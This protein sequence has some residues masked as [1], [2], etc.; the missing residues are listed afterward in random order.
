YESESKNFFCVSNKL[1]CQEIQLYCAALKKDEPIVVEDAWTHPATAELTEDYLRPH[2]IRSLLDIPLKLNG[3]ITGVLCLEV[4]KRTRGWEPQ[5]IALCLGVADHVSLAMGNAWE[6]DLRQQEQTRY[7][8]RLEHEVR[9]RTTALAVANE[10]LQE[11]EA[12]LQ[13]IFN[14]APFGAA[15]V[16]LYGHFVQVNEEFLRFVGYA[17]K[18]LAQVN[19]L[20]L[21][22]AEHRALY[23]ENFGALLAG[24]ISKFKADSL[25]LHHNDGS[26]WG[27]TTIRVLRDDSGAPLY[28][29]VLVENISEQKGY[30]DQLG[31][32]H[33]AIEQSPLSIL[34]TDPSGIIE[35]A[36]P[37]FCSVTGYELAEVVGQN[38]KVLKSNVHEPA[39]YQDLWQTIKAGK[40]WQGEICNLKKDGTPFWEYA[41]ISPVTDHDG[42]IVSYIAV[43]ENISARKKMADELRERSE[44]ITSIA[45]AALSA[46]I[47]I[48]NSGLISFWNKAAE[49]IFGWTRQEA[50][51]QDLHQLLVRD[52]CRQRFLVNF[53]QFQQS[54]AGSAIG[55]HVEMNALRKSGEEFPVELSLSS[56][57][58]QGK[59]HAVGI[60]N[61]ISERKEAQ[62]AILIARDEA[63]AANRAKS[64]FLARMSH[65]I[66]TPMNA[67]IGFSELALEMT[68][69]PKLTDYLGKIS[70]SGKNLLCIINDILDFSKIEAKKMTIEAHPFSLE[71]MLTDLASITTIKAEEKGV[72]FMFAVAP[73][74]PEQLVG[75]SLRLNQILINLV[76]NAIKF[77]EKGEVILEIAVQER[78]ADRITLHFSVRDTGVGLTEEQ[79]GK[80]FTPFSQADGS[81]S[82]NY[83]GTGLGLAICKRL[84]EL[85]QGG[86]EVHSC[87]GQGS[88]F[89]F[90][91]VLAVQEEC[92][93]PLAYSADLRVLVVEGYPAT[94]EIL[95]KALA[96]FAFMVTVVE[97]GEKG[98]EECRRAM[99]QGDPFDLVLLDYRLLGRNGEVV[100]EAVRA[101]FPAEQQPKVLVLTSTSA[102]HVVERCLAAGCD[103]V[104]VKP[105]SR[106]GL[107]A[108]INRFYDQRNHVEDS[109]ASSEE[110]AHLQLIY[111]ARVLVVEDILINQQLAEDIL[112]RVGVLVEIAN[113]G[114]E[115]LDL[116]YEKEFDLVLM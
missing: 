113:N 82:R 108:V 12:R 80:L 92:F 54:G 25:Y 47:M 35:Y 81:I 29:L 107:L 101:L 20:R 14:K 32:L 28:F 52:E 104:I 9:E 65:E 51:G 36:N 18:K 73:E 19:F 33:K 46:I 24:A 7:S 88:D 87:L 71:S 109:A 86:F 58:V 56:I 110:E 66:R 67:I 49:Q 3:E 69:P 40:T 111:G 15:L 43:K 5:E 94:R 106:V 85:M 99:E 72:E 17:E 60:V 26:V 55:R 91:A 84:V 31:K 79:I 78:S 77:T 75:D 6:K 105:V 61:D 76:A 74:V 115:A 42:K 38:P 103:D 89:S 21:V 98:L 112:C 68:L 16:N 34:I 13:L 63:E 4:K 90:T 100:I 37:F 44:I 10:A 59:W 116:L 45:T 70:S 83:G 95:R 23:E 97:D 64:D 57:R 41:L 62:K 39:F 2:E 93:T 96:S 30:E 48:D 1:S 8:V 50:L 102:A 22:Q 27:R 53:E 11:N 114:Q